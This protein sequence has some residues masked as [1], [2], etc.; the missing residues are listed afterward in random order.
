MQLELENNRE[1]CKALVR[2]ARAADNNITIANSSVTRDTTWKPEIVSKLQ[3]NLYDPDSRVGKAISQFK[4]DVKYIGKPS[5]LPD[6]QLC[7]LEI[8]DEIE[9]SRCPILD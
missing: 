3:Y 8:F 6:T 5:A 1:K 4:G 2:A 9:A 7:D